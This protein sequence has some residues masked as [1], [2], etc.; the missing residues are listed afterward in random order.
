M[1]TGQVAIV[2]ALIGAF[3]SIG[4]VWVE[5][6]ANK[7]GVE[8]NKVAVQK[9]GDSTTGTLEDGQKLCSLF[10]PNKWRDN[11]VVP[12]SWSKDIC[13]SLGVKVGATRYQLGCVFSNSAELGADVAINQTAPSP[14]RTCGW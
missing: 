5:S 8:S 10:D 11:V 14:A 4:K 3:A 12:K 9:L 1:T 2:V 6:A 13:M 7:A